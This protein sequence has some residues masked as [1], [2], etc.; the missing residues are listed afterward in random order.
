MD[1]FAIL[2]P[3]IIVGFLA[4]FTGRLII[5]YCKPSS[6]SATVSAAAATDNETPN[7]F[8]RVTNHL[9]VSN[10]PHTCR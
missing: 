7:E 9:F 5:K 8:S 4:F 1:M 2:T 3:V 10:T 6:T